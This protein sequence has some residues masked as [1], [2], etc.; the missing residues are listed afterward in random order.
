[1]APERFDVAVV[2]GGA[3]GIAAALAAARSGARTLLVERGVELGGNAAQALVHTICGLYLPADR[4]SERFAHPGF[5]SRFAAALQRAGAAGAPERAGRVWVLPTDPPRLSAVARSLCEG[6]P[7][8]ELRRCTQVVAAALATEGGERLS[9]TLLAD[10]G[11]RRSVCSAVVVDASGD[12]V[13]AQLAG[14]TLEMAPP[15]A[16]Q[17]P[18][19]IFRLAGVE[20]ASLDE[21]R[22]FSR[23]RVTHAVAGAVRDGA[24]PAGCE[25]V[26]VRPG[27]E[28]GCI[29]V[30]LNVPR[31]ADR[32][33][34][35]LDPACRRALESQARRRA[36]QVVAFLRQTR[37]PF[38]KCR[39]DAWPERL[40]VRETRRVCGR[41]TVTRD[42]VLEGRRGDDEVA[43][44][45][46][47]IELWQD[48]RRAQLVHPTGPSSVPL[49]ALVSRSHPRLAMAG[50]CLSADREAMGALRVLGTAL[51]TGEA[52]G[53]AAALAADAGTPV[54][55]VAPATVRHHILEQAG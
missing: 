18:S 40:G 51:A 36:E 8:L 12:A 16:L 22:G 39:V 45:T 9:L 52:A 34:E 43:L 15:A 42:H 31:P 17:L 26:L 32:A 47:P 49:G 41:S 50:R 23:L 11:E 13:V 48:H 2:G 10:G 37:A 54:D 5:P 46:W 20:T 55:A 3:A 29:Y 7:E 28:P 44:S 1:V 6:A 14:A 35:P 19:Y 27:G 4:G 33:Y 21:L 53:I 38:E 25:A 30:T 24:L